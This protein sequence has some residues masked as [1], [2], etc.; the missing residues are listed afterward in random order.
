MGSTPAISAVVESLARRE[1]QEKLEAPYEKA[2]GKLIIRFSLL[3]VTLEQYSWHLWGIK[4]RSALVTRDLPTTHLVEKLRSTA[5]S[6][7]PWEKDRKDFLFILK[8]VERVAI[9][10]NELLHSLWIIREGQNLSVESEAHSLEL[11]RLQLRTLTN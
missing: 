5:Q 7:I 2:L 10:R 3:H 9:R 1:M 4:G 11:R 6:V 8:K